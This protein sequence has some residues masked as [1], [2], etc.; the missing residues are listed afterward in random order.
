[1]FGKY[2]ARAFIFFIEK[3]KRH[4]SRRLP[5]PFSIFLFLPFPMKPMIFEESAIG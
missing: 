5:F 4:S 1:L 2:A 3:G